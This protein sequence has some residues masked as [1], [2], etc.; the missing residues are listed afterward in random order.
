MNTQLPTNYQQFI[1]LSRYARWNEAQQRRETWHETVSRYFDF[2][3]KHLDLSKK[4]EVLKKENQ[5]LKSN[6]VQDE[7]LNLENIQLRK[8]IDEQDVFI[9]FSLAKQLALTLYLY[10]KEQSKEVLLQINKKK[11]DLF[12]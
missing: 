1:H 7:F 6:I 9:H 12:C 8:L 5:I 3:E 11:N 10:F 2:F 4:Y